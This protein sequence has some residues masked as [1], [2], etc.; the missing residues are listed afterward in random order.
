MKYSDT[1]FSCIGYIEKHVKE[2]LT[3]QK[4]ASEVGYSLF[5]LSHI[6]KNEMG[7]SIMDYVKE[8]KLISASY[9]LFEG[10][11]IIDVALEYGYQTH[12]GF[13]KAFKKQFGFPPS[14][15]YAM[16]MSC[17]LL[18][19]GDDIMSLVEREKQGIFVKQTVDFTIPEVLYTSLLHTIKV[20]DVKGDLKKIEKA[21]QMACTAHQDERRKS[22][23]AYIIHPL[24]VANILAEMEASEECI[25]AGLLHEILE[26]DTGIPI[27]DVK[28]EFSEG[29]VEIIQ[30]LTELN[31]V[32]LEN[33]WEEV[34][35]RDMNCILIKLADRLHNMRTIKYM[36]SDKLK[37]KAK[38]TIEFFSPIANR[39]GISKIKIELDDLA[40]KYL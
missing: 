26:K 27:E 6:F 34:G 22:G 3:A 33:L 8:R 10:K 35:K 24:C 28:K 18:S 5:R 23:E 7:M 39:L 21:Y 17:N 30:G 13:T 4:I 32:K 20:N 9:A 1:M 37:E 12:S 40:L 19:K 16:R 38:E 15:I 36:E 11:K 14:F 29:V 31:R 25:I 2:T